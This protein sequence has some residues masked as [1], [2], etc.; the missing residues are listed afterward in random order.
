MMSCSRARLLRRGSV[1]QKKAALKQMGKSSPKKINV[2]ANTQVD[3]SH[4]SHALE[5]MLKQLG[6]DFPSACSTITSDANHVENL[7]P[8]HA[9]KRGSTISSRQYSYDGLMRKVC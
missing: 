6:S 3:T 2:E 1:A 9:L 8:I 5:E 4:L 7:R